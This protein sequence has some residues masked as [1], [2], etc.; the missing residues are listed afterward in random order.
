MESV[1]DC[2][3]KCCGEKTCEVA[4]LVE[5]KCH[6]VEC[7]GDELCQ[8]FPVEDEKFSPTIVYMNKRNGKRMKDKG[9]AGNYLRNL[10]NVQANERFFFTLY[11]GTCGSPCTSGVCTAKDKCTCDRGFAGPSCN[12]TATEGKLMD[13]FI[14]GICSTLFISLCFG[15]TIP[16]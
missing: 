9:E 5:S 8:S 3:D 7:Y 16:L 11:L 13:V 14:C 4:F 2:I 10:P 12:D 1:E 15:L 6:S